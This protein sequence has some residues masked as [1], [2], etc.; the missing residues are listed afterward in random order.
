MTYYQV[1]FVGLPSSGKSSI[2]NSLLFK[3]QLQSGVCRTT[4][5]VNIVNKEIND[6][7]NNKFKVI[8]LPG[9]CDSEESDIKFNDLTYQHVKEANLIYWVS[10]VN[11]AFITT[12]EVNEYNHLKEYVEKLHKETGRLYHMA[13]MLSKCDKDNKK[14]VKQINKIKLL[15]DDEIVDSDEDTN[16]GDLIDKVKKKFPQDDILLFNA[17]G[18]SYHHKK[19]SETLKNF[20]IKMVGVPS[21]VNITFDIT[22]YITNYVEDQKDSYFNIFLLRFIDFINFLIPLNKLILFWN[23]ITLEQKQS[24]LL[25]LIEDH[26]IN[27][28][29]NYAIYEYLCF[30]ID[31]A[32]LETNVCS[33]MLL[34]YYDD[35]LQNGYL[36]K[37]QNQYT[38][39]S[40]PDEIITKYVEE[41]EILDYDDKIKRYY[42]LLTKSN[43]SINYAKRIILALKNEGSY[44]E[45]NH[46]LDFNQIITCDT[47]YFN[48]YYEIITIWTAQFD[49]NF[50]TENN[51]L[52]NVHNYLDHLNKLCE[53]SEYIHLNKLQIA[54]CLINKT[55][56]TCHFNRLCMLPNKWKMH[57]HKRL[58]GNSEYVNVITKIWEQIYSNV[59]FE[60]DGDY[61]DFIPLDIQELCYGLGIID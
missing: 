33:N 3:R 20:V 54:N 17:Y 58:L 59:L 12:H 42:F 47:N 61:I 55:D 53:D 25:A 29:I 48:R 45:F 27:H 37:T 11:K 22:K 5:D 4:T 56:M 1:A 15:D 44:S 23:N 36:K 16:I 52:C 40:S 6:D 14:C 32:F 7:K 49:F 19:A 38:D 31:K 34:D 43:L 9:I 46:K 35:I 57:I 24:H 26:E 50:N 51:S 2:I 10:D 13:I 28:K 41:Y 8:D 39:Y 18:R 60:Y 21:N 30:V